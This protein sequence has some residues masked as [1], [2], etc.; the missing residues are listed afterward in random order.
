MLGDSLSPAPHPQV[1]LGLPGPS[2]PLTLCLTERY[3]PP[4]LLF[5]FQPPATL[6]WPWRQVH[7][8]THFGTAKFFASHPKSQ[9]L[10]PCG[11]LRQLQTASWEQPH[12]HCPPQWCWRFFS[13]SQLSEHLPCFASHAAHFFQQPFLKHKEKTMLSGR[14]HGILLYHEPLR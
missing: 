8:T 12:P 2:Y 9:W 7:G 6:C 1:Q 11:L 5:Y 10:H 3:L 13:Q 4:L 14:L